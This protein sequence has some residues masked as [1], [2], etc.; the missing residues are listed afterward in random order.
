MGATPSGRFGLLETPLVSSNL[1]VRPSQSGRTAFNK[2]TVD[3]GCRSEPHVFE[4]V[5]MGPNGGA[6]GPADRSERNF[7]LQKDKPPMTPRLFPICIPMQHSCTPEADFTSDASRRSR[8]SS[9]GDHP[10]HLRGADAELLRRIPDAQ[11]AADRCNNATL[12]RLNFRP[13]EAPPPMPTGHHAAA[14]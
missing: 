8:R 14:G 2:N 12:V 1:N 11:P 5:P 3:N 7:L 10:L 4:G 9:L 13:S 6:G